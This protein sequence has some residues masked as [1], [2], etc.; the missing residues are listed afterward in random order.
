MWV[1]RH[2]DDYLMIGP[3]QHLEVLHAGMSTKLGLRDIVFLDKPGETAQFL[4]WTITKQSGGFDLSVNAE[5]AADVIRDEGLTSSTSTRGGTTPGSKD[6][7]VDE[8][9]VSAEEHRY[10]RTQVGRLLFYGVLRPDMQFGIT[11][12]SK[13]VHQ[14]TVSDMIALKRLCKYLKNTMHYVLRLRPVGR[15]LRVEAW[16]DADWAGSHDRRS[17]SGGIIMVA[18]A[19]VLSFARTQATRALSSCE[20]ELYA[21]GSTAAEAMLVAAFLKEQRLCDE[22][23]LIHSDSSSAL[24]LAR[25]HGQGRL[26]HVEVRLLALQ[27]WQAEGRIRLQKVASEHNLADVLTKWVSRLILA[28]LLPQIGL[29]DS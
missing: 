4:G 24:A 1:V 19:L 6:R 28:A 18:G 8:T 15:K 14:P 22:P 27:D 20:S 13:A 9:P 2:M 3:R 25:K 5:L 12:L 26:R 29:G 10:Y 11:Q 16:S 17:T 21:I 23:P 7:V